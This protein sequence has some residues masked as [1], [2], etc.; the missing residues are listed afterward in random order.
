M[1]R[2]ADPSVEENVIGT[3]TRVPA[4]PLPRGAFRAHKRT[5][6][7]PGYLRGCVHRPIPTRDALK[8]QPLGWTR[9]GDKGGFRRI[10][11]IDL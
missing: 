2:N 10:A 8:R 3:A 9:P 1:E 6:I 7:I 11:V 5:E 4:N